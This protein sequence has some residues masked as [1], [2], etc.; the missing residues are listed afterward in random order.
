VEGATTSQIPFNTAHGKKRLLEETGMTQQA[1]GVHVNPS[2][3]SI[4]LRPRATQ[5]E[6]ARRNNSDQGGS[7]TRAA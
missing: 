1:F 4:R 3:E 6:L 2:E 7:S 5:L